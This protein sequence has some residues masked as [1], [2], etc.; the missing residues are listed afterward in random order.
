MINY[1][2]NCKTVDVY[3]K[4][5][6]LENVVYNVHWILEGED[7]ETAYRGDCIGTQILNTSN[8]E[9]FVPVEELTNEIITGW[10]KSTIGEESVAKLEQTIAKKIQEQAEPT[11]ITMTI[12]D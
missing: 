10:V 9:T 8:I 12:G 4:E 3:P 2:W 5:G 1:T 6:E 11:T 7:S